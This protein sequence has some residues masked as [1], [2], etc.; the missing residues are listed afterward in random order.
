MNNV[1]RIV[2]LAGLF[3]FILSNSILACESFPYKESISYKDLKEATSRYFYGLIFDVVVLN[4]SDSIESK[5][6]VNVPVRHTDSHKQVGVEY[7]KE[8]YTMVDHYNNRLS[9][10]GAILRHCYDY[11]HSDYWDVVYYRCDSQREKFYDLLRTYVSRIP[12]GKGRLLGGLPI[13]AYEVHVDLATGDEQAGLAL[14]P[15]LGWIANS[16]L[17]HVGMVVQADNGKW[18][19]MQKEND[20]TNTMAE[21]HS[22][23]EARD[24]IYRTC[25]EGTPNRTWFPCAQPTP[26]PKEALNQFN[27]NYNSSYDLLGNNCK[28][29]VYAFMSK[30]NLKSISVECRRSDGIFFNRCSGKRN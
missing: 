3:G 4:S 30:F 16:L 18:Y 21:Y 20:G 8:A 25:R 1:H 10:G 2:I 19:A 9:K 28:D 17:F 29:Y 11:H 22:F 5:L 13:C 24:R 15:I 26:I 12:T 7:R 6:I 14:V 23:T 27:E